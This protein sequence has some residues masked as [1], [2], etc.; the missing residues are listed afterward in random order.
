MGRCVCWIHISRGT[1]HQPREG[2]GGRSAGLENRRVNSA[3]ARARNRCCNGVRDSPEDCNRTG[4]CCSLSRHLYFGGR[5]RVVIVECAVN[6]FGHGL[7]FSVSFRGYL[8]RNIGGR[9]NICRPDSIPHGF[10]WCRIPLCFPECGCTP[11]SD[12][13]FL[14]SCPCR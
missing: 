13:F 1:K 9:L 2:A 10:G 12:R 14:R 11:V 5:I 7:G 6:E 8:H 3:D 4:F